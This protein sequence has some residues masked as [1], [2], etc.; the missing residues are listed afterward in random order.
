MKNFLFSLNDFL[1]K[2][3]EKNVD[4]MPMGFTKLIAYYYTNAKIRKI[5]LKKLGF[6]MGDGTYSNLGLTFIPND[7]L[8]P[9]VLIGNNVSIGPNVTFIANS[10]PNNSNLLKNIDYIK[11]NLIHTNNIN[12]III[13]DDVWLG[14]GCIIMP[15][16]RIKKG[17]II[18]AGA[19]V[20]ND[21]EEF[22]TYAGTPAKKIRCYNN[23]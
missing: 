6:M 5:Y 1:D 15:N 9:S 2:F 18:G 10:E 17:S 16:V 7:D 11:E 22:C 8:S 4:N 12:S 20:L 14:A 21:T 13:E 23:Q 3:L 19:V